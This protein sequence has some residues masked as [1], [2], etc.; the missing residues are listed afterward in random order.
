SRLGASELE[1]I[2]AS[3]ALIRPGPIKGNMVEPF[4]NR[5]QGL[6]PVTYLH[7]KLESILAKTYG[8]VLFQEQVLEIAQ[9]IAGF[10]PGEADRLR[11]VMSHARS[12]QDMEKIGQDFVAKSVENG[13]EQ[14]VAETIFSYMAGYASYGFC[15]AHAAAF[16]TTAF[17]TGYLVEH[18]PAEFFAAVL[19]Q[20]PMGFY[21]PNTLCVELRRRGIGILPPDVNKSGKDFSVEQGDVRISLARVKNMTEEDLIKLL[22]ARQDREFTSFHDFCRRSGARKDVLESL[23]LCGACDGLHS[24]RRQLYWSIESELQARHMEESALLF[25]SHEPYANIPDY[26]PEEK[27]YNEYEILGINSRQHFMAFWREKYGI[28]DVLTTREV[29]NV[30]DGQTVT[31]GGM[32][33]RPHRPPTKS[34]KTVVFLSLEDE[35]GLIDITVFQDVYQQYGNFL[36]GG[37]RP[38]LAVTGTVQRRGQGLSVT[39]W[40]LE[41]LRKYFNRH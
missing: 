30:P 6:E 15:E 24:N 20:Q 35:F 18:Y 22:A 1:D 8:V 9:E 16:A 38:P 27:L 11:R 5:R 2:V 34:G 31:V 29:T 23:V 40:K 36:F 4:I 21:S 25:E 7:P 10:S 33:I 13:V 28:T 19:S 26:T 37:K 32:V 14:G 17:K 41:D 39:A 3:V 12:R